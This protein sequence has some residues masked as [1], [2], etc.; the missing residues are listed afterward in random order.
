MGRFMSCKS[1]RKLKFIERIRFLLNLKVLS[2]LTY[3]LA[4]FSNIFVGF[5]NHFR[6]TS[7]FLG[8]EGLLFGW[9]TSTSKMSFLPLLSNLIYWYLILFGK[10]FNF[11]RLFFCLVMIV[12]GLFI[13]NVTGVT[14]EMMMDRYH[15]TLTPASGIYLWLS[16]YIVLSI[17]YFI[18]DWKLYRKLK[19]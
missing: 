18:G 16:S 7:E 19:K 11:L 13:F 4:L 15:Y 1:F 5:E 8:I 14:V 9:F 2:I 3:I 12:S 6:V 10:Y 17:H